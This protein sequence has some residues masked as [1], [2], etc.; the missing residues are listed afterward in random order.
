MKTKVS[1]GL[2]LQILE[3]AESWDRAMPLYGQIFGPDNDGGL[4]ILEIFPRNRP[5]RI[6]RNPAWQAVALVGTAL[7]LEDEE[8]LPGL[9]ELYRDLHGRDHLAP[10]LRILQE[11]GTPHFYL[12]YAS[13]PDQMHTLLVPPRR[14]ELDAAW[15]SDILHSVLPCYATDDRADWGLV[16]DEDT[17]Y[18][19]GEPEL[20]RRFVAESGGMEEL[21][22]IFSLYI[23]EYVTPGEQDYDGVAARFYRRL[24][25]YCGWEW[26]FPEPPPA[27]TP[28][29]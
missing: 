9:V 22:R 16:I 7:S 13:P 8:P 21:V 27:P 29:A 24:Y 28:E 6:F 15:L 25:T 3:P 2:E 14:L 10:L 5:P 26:P 1:N 4:N 12:A 18:L 17:M 19:G 20:M 11:R 23:V